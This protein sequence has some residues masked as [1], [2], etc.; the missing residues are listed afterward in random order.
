M[1]LTSTDIAPNPTVK[2]YL[3]FVFTT[4][5][6]DDLLLTDLEVEVELVLLRKHLLPGRPHQHVELHVDITLEFLSNSFLSSS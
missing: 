3:E 6:P 1:P 5:V 4:S 2:S